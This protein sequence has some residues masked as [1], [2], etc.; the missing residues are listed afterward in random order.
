MS[1]LENKESIPVLL[2]EMSNKEKIDLLV[3]NT[4]F[5]SLAMPQYGIP[6][7]RYLDG[8]TGVNLLQYVMEMMGDITAE[9]AEKKEK[10]GSESNNESG[11][12]AMDY[13]KYAC[14][15]VPVP[16]HFLDEDKKMVKALRV[17]MKATRPNGEE[18]GCFP[19]GMLLGAAWNPDVVYKIGEAVAREAM[20]YGVE[21]L[22]GTPN[23]N[24]H[25]DSKNGRVFE[26]FSEDPYLSKKLAPV[27]AKSVQDQGMIAGRNWN[28]SIKIRLRERKRKNRM[29]NIIERSE[30]L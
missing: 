26:S 20:A 11:A 30:S 18:P 25:R 10:T 8:A 6:A 23:T 29:E 14:S 27:F 7:I 3:G 16:E 12:G 21:V 28:G 5:S 2:K 1:K 9:K 22:L 24:I 15:E 13:V 19:P 4:F 17:N